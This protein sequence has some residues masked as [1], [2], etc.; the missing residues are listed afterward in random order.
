MGWCNSGERH[1]RAM[2]KPHHQTPTGRV[3]VAIMQGK[4]AAP[5]DNHYRMEGRAAVLAVVKLTNTGSPPTLHSRRGGV[6]GRQ[7]LQRMLTYLRRARP[8]G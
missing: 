5:G 2:C 7:R 8:V 3:A 6:I 1:G 4:T